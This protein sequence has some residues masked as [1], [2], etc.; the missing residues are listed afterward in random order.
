MRA[1]RVHEDPVTGERS[2]GPR[3]GARPTDEWAARVKT[4]RGKREIVG[5]DPDDLE[6]G[7]E[8]RR[9]EP[10]TAERLKEQAAKPVKTKRRARAERWPETFRSVD[11][12]VQAF[13]AANGDAWSEAEHHDWIDPLRDWMD[14]I[15]VRSGRSY[16][17]KLAKTAAGVRILEA[18][19]KPGAQAIRAALRYLFGRAGSRR[20]ANVP[21]AE[22]RRL[23]ETMEHAGARPFAWYPPQADAKP[24]SVEAHN[25]EVFE[26]ELG[27]LE[28]VYRAARRNLDDSTRRLWQR[29]LRALRKLG[30]NARALGGSSIC[31]ATIEGACQF[32]TLDRAAQELERA[33]RA[34]GT[35]DRGSRAAPDDLDLPWENPSTPLRGRAVKRAPVQLHGAELADLLGSALE[36]ELAKGVV[37][38]WRKG[39]NILAWHPKARACVWI[40]GGRRLD[41]TAKGDAKV[42]DAFR[43]WT[44]RK[45]KASELVKFR[46]RESWVSFGPC[47][48]FDYFSKKWPRCG[49]EYTHKTTTH[50]TLYRLGGTRP[51][52]V[53]VLRG[54]GLQLTTRGLV[55]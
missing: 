21:W 27:E 16:H 39:T 14:R 49:P 33:R 19:R 22:V 46:V 26:R 1:A 20:W 6:R 10:E 55:G 17:S 24:S 18:A 34:P 8:T 3:R 5:V 25:L 50:P 32:P 54:G 52:W 40:Q 12:G 51:P 23:G 45:A 13:L 4:R 41:G 38:R 29:R 44:G 43:R 36:L 42:R 9:V 48:R 30:A 7:T 28:K 2:L 37:I 11:D 15:E 35:Q 53:W 31:E 47:E